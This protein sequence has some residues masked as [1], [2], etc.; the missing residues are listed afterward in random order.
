MSLHMGQAVFPFSARRSFGDVCQP[1]GVQQYPTE[2][3]RHGQPGGG[4]PESQGFA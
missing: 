4:E 1:L 3:R 2:T